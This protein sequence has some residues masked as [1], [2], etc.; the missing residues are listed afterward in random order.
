MRRHRGDEAGFT[1][2][3]LLVVLGV[4]GILTSIALPS[5]ASQ[6]EKARGAAVRA[7]LRSASTAEETLAAEGL[8]YAPGGAAGLAVL[9]ANGHNETEGVTVS[10]V[11]GDSDSYCLRA[12]AAGVPTMYLTNVGTVAGRITRTVCV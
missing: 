6:K 12:D 4:I 1:L 5:L 10:V 2:I 11:S 9:H 3:E 7:A 8:P